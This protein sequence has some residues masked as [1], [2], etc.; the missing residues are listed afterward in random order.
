[1]KYIYEQKLSLN[2][3]YFLPNKFFVSIVV[4]NDFLHA[5]PS[6]ILATT[7]LTAATFDMREHLLKWCEMRNVNKLKLLDVKKM[8][9]KLKLTLLYRN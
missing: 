7:T 5:T 1:M 6:F 8:V 2:S 4:S 9:R 3:I